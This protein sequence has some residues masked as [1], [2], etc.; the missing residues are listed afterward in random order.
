MS[1]TSILALISI[2]V[3]LICTAVKCKEI[4]DSISETA[5][6]VDNPKVFTGIML[7]EASLLMFPLLQNSS[8]NTQWLAFLTVV[9]LIMVALTPK[10]KT[11]GGIAHYA[12]GML[13]GIASQALIA[14]N[15]PTILY[16]WA[17]FPLLYLLSKEDYTYWAELICL[18]N[19][20]IF[21]L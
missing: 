17:A 5:Y 18:I 11:E 7:T 3:Y 10:Y 13:S 1:L 8:E 16:S 12:G 21:I 14:L 6:I 19:I 9:G 4:P 2:A 15:E 20:F